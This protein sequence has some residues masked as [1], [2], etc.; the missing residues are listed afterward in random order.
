LPGPIRAKDRSPT[1]GAEKIEGRGDARLIPSSAPSSAVAPGVRSRTNSGAATM[2]DDV[3][4]EVR[5]KVQV[6]GQDDFRINFNFTDE[7]QPVYIRSNRTLIGDQSQR[8]E[9]LAT[10]FVGKI[11]EII[12]NVQ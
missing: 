2:A 8:L 1:G 3:K 11:A 10:N 9:N 4:F 6:A 7:S 5:V 12:F